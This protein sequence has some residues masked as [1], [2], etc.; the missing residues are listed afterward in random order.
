MI[1]YSEVDVGPGQL[2]SII[3]KAENTKFESFKKR[4]NEE[5]MV[6]IL[7]HITYG[8]LAVVLS[9]WAEKKNNTSNHQMTY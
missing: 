3:D 9:F 5:N 1:N 4:W 8:I 6:I 7:I 2:C